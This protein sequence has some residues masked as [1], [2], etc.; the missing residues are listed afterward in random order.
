[1][2]PLDGSMP[3]LDGSGRCLL[4]GVGRKPQALDDSESG[5]ARRASSQPNWMQD[6][7]SNGTVTKSQCQLERQ[8]LAIS[9][10]KARRQIPVLACAER[11]VQCIRARI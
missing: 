4:N 11:E 8:F 2:P 9:T 10:A 1:M 6:L 7:P 5:R 3:P